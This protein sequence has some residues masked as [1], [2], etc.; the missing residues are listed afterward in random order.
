LPALGKPARVGIGFATIIMKGERDR[1]RVTLCHSFGARGSHPG[2]E[3][4]H[5][6]KQRQRADDQ[7]YFGRHLCLLIKAGI[8][9]VMSEQRLM[10]A[11]ENTQISCSAA[12]MTAISSIFRES[13]VGFS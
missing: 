9:R 10:E 5:S 13:R 11:S 7:E 4:G 1:V 3:Q 2:E 8:A 12:A 6:G